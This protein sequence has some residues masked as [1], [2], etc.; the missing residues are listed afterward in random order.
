[1]HTACVLRAQ[2]SIARRYRLVNRFHFIE[3]AGQV[4]IP[5]PFDFAWQFSEAWLPRGR[6]DAPGS[7]IVPARLSSHPV[8]YARAFHEGLAEVQLGGL[9]GFVNRRV[10]V[11]FKYDGYQP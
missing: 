2:L 9:W 3:L 5:P 6:T 11:D 10:A 8:S 7:S 4:V 1:M